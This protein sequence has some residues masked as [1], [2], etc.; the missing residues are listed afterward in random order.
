MVV[1]NGLWTKSRWRA[2]ES[3]YKNSNVLPQINEWQSSGSCLEEF[4][5]EQK[6][7]FLFTPE[8]DYLAT[9][10]Y[11]AKNYEV[12]VVYIMQKQPSRSVLRKR[13]SGNIH[14]IYRRTLVP[15]CEF[16]KVDLLSCKFSVYFQNTFSKVQL[17]T[18]ASDFVKTGI[19][20]KSV[21]KKL[22]FDERNK[23]LGC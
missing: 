19:W 3:F 2:I 5:K 18:A 7:F 21:I 14:Q 13:S 8:L 1:L 23:S 6:V 20:P 22:Q 11:L 16:N 17:W 9:A 10:G 4:S 12:Y 15:K